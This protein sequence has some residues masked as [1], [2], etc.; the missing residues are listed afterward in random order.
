[1]HRRS[2]GAPSGAIVEEAADDED[3]GGEAEGSVA[4]VGAAVGVAAELPVV[5]PP[6][7]GGFDDSAHPESEGLFAGLFGA[8]AL[9]VEVVE[10]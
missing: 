6:G 10:A 4:V 8:A 9:D 7:V 5:G 2:R 1:V 3:G